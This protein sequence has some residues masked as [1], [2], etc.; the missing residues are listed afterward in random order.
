MRTRQCREASKEAARRKPYLVLRVLLEGVHAL[1]HPLDVGRHLRARHLPLN[2]L[3]VG[4]VHH[5]HRVLY[6]FWRHLRH[7]LF[8]RLHL[9]RCLHGEDAHTHTHT[10][11]HRRRRNRSQR[12]S[13]KTCSP[14]ARGPAPRGETYHI[15]HLLHGELHHLGVHPPWRHHRSFPLPLWRFPSAD[16]LARRNF[17]VSGCLFAESEN[18]ENAFEMTGEEQ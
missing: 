14:S 18:P 7:L 2:L 16:C 4:V 13:R 17:F 6:R 12:C 3:G 15:F 9:L 1:L 5:V 10:H 11:T 8:H